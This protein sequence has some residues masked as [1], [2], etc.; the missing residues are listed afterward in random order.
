M[1]ANQE[2]MSTQFMIGDRC[3]AMTI[4]FPFRYGDFGFM[5]YE[6]VNLPT[7]S[8]NW[9]P[10]PIPHSIPVPSIE[11]SGMGISLDLGFKFSYKKTKRR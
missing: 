5:L 10:R 4:A 7:E 11:N 2:I 3:F 6:G 8:F 9:D 1:R